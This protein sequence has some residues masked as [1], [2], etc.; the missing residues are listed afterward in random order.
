MI[1]NDLLRR[2]LSEA[3]E[4][5]K[6]YMDMGKVLPPDIRRPR[7]RSVMTKNVAYASEAPYYMH[8]KAETACKNF[9]NAYNVGDIVQVWY[10]KSKWDSTFGII[11]QK[12]RPKEVYAEHDDFPSNEI[13]WNAVCEVA[14]IGQSHSIHEH[15]GFREYR[16]LNTKDHIQK[17]TFEE[18]VEFRRDGLQKSL[19]TIIENYRVLKRSIRDYKYRLS[20]NERDLK[21]FF[22]EA[23]QRRLKTNN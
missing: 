12:A 6:E 20:H 10:D 8:Q 7:F 13:E 3:F 2:L 21:A 4:K 15:D 22:E 1:D 19:E 5:N 17:V 14:V 23:Q 18:L 9:N 11:G 16:L